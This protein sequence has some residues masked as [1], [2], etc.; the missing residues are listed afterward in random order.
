MKL[1]HQVAPV[2]GL[3]CI[4][5]LAAV[6][7][8]AADPSDG[9][10]I[11]DVALSNVEGES[12]VIKVVDATVASGKEG[13]FTVSINAK[14]GFKVNDQYPHKVNLDDPPSGVALPKQKLK[15]GDGQFEGKSFVFKIPVKAESAGSHT[16][17]GN[18]KFSVCNDNQCLIKDAAIQA[19]I[20][21]PK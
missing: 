10:S 8:A 17:G 21:V 14:D 13:T 3:A 5:A 7:A 19:K 1:F 20:T 9:F 2:F 15:K 18:V 11:Q 6:P 4:A 16:V 12:F